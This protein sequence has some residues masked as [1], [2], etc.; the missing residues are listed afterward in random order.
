MA[1]TL[2]L[3]SAQQP[4]SQ[5]G[6]LSGRQAGH[7]APVRRR[8]GGA[9]LKTAPSAHIFLKLAQLGHS[10]VL[11]HGQQMLIHPGAT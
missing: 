1:A 3:A 5:A 2:Y 10:L 6:R 7:G 11:R 4:R 9:P 8:Q